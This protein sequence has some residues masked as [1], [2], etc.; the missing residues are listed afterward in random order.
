MGLSGTAPVFTVDG[1]RLEVHYQPVVVLPGRHIVGFEA[2]ARLRRPDGAL[3]Q[4]EHFVPEA[5]RSGLIVPLGEAVLR[6][7][8]AQASLWKAANGS[9]ATATVSV[10]VAPAQLLDPGFDEVVSRILAEHGVPGSSLILE[11][12][13]SAVAS[14]RVRPVLD[15]LAQAGVRAALDD[16]GVGFATLDNLR[17]LP[18]HVLKLDASFVAGVTREGTDRAIVRVV[19]DLADRLGMSVIAEG[20]E[21]KEQV[22]ILIRL[23]CPAAQGHLFALPH[24]DPA[25]AASQVI[26]P[27]QVATAPD[28]EPPAW[29]AHVDAAVLGSARLLAGGTDRHRAAV[30]TVAMALGRARALPALSVRLIGRLAMVHDLARLTVDGAIPGPMRSEPPLVELAGGAGGGM[31]GTR[32]EEAA[33]VRRSVAI[34]DEARRRDHALGVATVASVLR[35]QAASTARDGVPGGAEPA[36]LAAADSLA[37]IPSLGELLEDLDC[38]RRGR[39]GMEDRVSALLGISRVLSSSSDSLELLTAGLEEV[40]RIVG[41]ASASLERWEREGGI[42]RTLVNVGQLGPGEE[43]L[44]DDEIYPLSESAQARRT[45][46]SGLPYVHTVDDADADVEAV[47]LLKQLR[48]YSSAAIP[49][50]LEGRIWGQLWLTTDVGDPPFRAADV[51]RLTAIATLMSVVVAHAE[52]LGHMARLAFEDPLTRVGNRR[53]V[54]DGLE[55]LAASGR[56]TTVMLIDVDHLK[57]IND[58][59]G[60]ASGDKAL[61]RVSDA[62]SHEL[63]RLPGASVGRLGGDEFCVLAPDCTTPQAEG[64]IRSVRDLLLQRWGGPGISAGIATATTAWCPR[65]MLAAADTDLYRAKGSRPSAPQPSQAKTAPE[66]H[67]IR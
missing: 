33:L 55:Q 45:L 19:I 21:T 30:Y 66:N 65:D 44:P 29:S 18:V 27:Q 15:R 43:P 34:V 57:Q 28:E 7:A 11:I 62:L 13:E 5:E 32:S 17:R 26:P 22:Q 4:P 59:S 37:A 25:V 48:K 42:V 63:P 47:H 60:H 16:F 10:N 39:C 3:V 2:L 54:D 8:V 35:E 40:R 6:R 9:I 38:R 61:I 50:Y 12:T 52:S 1:G 53:A 64:W 58:T 51:E 23:G 56:T 41:A 20:V 31:S 49:L 36:L 24:P 46:L 14:P 67:M